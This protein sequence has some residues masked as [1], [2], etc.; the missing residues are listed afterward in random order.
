M[1]EG[2]G[3]DFMRARFYDAGQGRFTQQDPLHIY[4]GLN[5][6][7]YANNSPVNFIDPQDLNQM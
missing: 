4:G 5:L 3:L 7:R 2:N 6:Y 1:N